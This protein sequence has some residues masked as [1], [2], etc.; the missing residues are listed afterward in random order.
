MLFDEFIKQR[1]FGTVALVSNIT[2]GIL[3]LQQHADRASVRWYRSCLCSIGEFL[4]VDGCVVNVGRGRVTPQTY[5]LPVYRSTPVV[6]WSS[7]RNPMS[8]EV[9]ELRK[10]SPAQ[11]GRHYTQA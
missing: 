5:R 4:L 11:G 3:A 6:G 9:R 8:E 10:E 1:L 7:S 2:R